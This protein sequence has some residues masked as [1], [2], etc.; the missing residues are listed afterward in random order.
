[1]KNVI[2][3]FSKTGGYRFKQASLDKMQQ[4]YIAYLKALVSFLGCAETGNYIIS[5]CQISGANITAGL[6]YIDGEL[7]PFE[8]TTGTNSTLIS[9]QV[10]I[11]TLNFKNG[12]DQPVFRELKAIKVSSGGTALSAFTRFN[13]VQDANYVHTDANFTAALL[14]KLN[15]IA[16]GAEVNVQANF[17]QNDNTADDYIKNKPEGNLLTYLQKGIYVIGDV[18]TGFETI[19]INI[20]NVGTSNYAVLGDMVSFGS[21]DQHVFWK[22]REHNPTYFKLQ[23]RDIVNAGGQNLK[24]YFFIVPN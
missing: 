19:T 15:G 20:P 5:G 23:L 16:A 4:T 8:Q 9:K 24:F 21:N 11:T 18:I 6:M 10:T 12:V 7:C 14:A 2:I 22:T 1:M 17:T 3:D 13:Y